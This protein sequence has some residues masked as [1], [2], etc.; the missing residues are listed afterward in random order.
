MSA[1]NLVCGAGNGFGSCVP[2]AFNVVTVGQAFE[3]YLVFSCTLFNSEVAN[4]FALV[5]EAL[6]E[7]VV[8]F[9]CYGAGI[10]LLAATAALVV[11][12]VVEGVVLEE[13]AAPAVATFVIAAEQTGVGRKSGEG[14]GSGDG[15]GGVGSDALAVEAEHEEALVSVAVRA[16]VEVDG[17]SSQ[18]SSL[19]AADGERHLVVVAIEPRLQTLNIHV[20][21]RYV[22]DVQRQ[23]ERC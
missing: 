21:V 2:C 10:G 3:D 9:A 13:E 14:V 8:A 12:G 23:V 16:A 4:T 6:E 15:E 18:Q 20:D 1:D 11:G 22:A 17:V 19:V 7:R 5:G